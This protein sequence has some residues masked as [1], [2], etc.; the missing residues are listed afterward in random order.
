LAWSFGQQFTPFA[1]RRTSTDSCVIGNGIPRSGTYLV[2]NILQNLGGWEN[3]GVHI[4][5]RTW[6]TWQRDGRVTIHPC[7]ARFALQK[8]RNGQIVGAHLPWSRELEKAMGRVTV[9]RRIKQVFIH[10]DPRDTFVSYLSWVTTSERFL[11]TA[12]GKEFRKFMLEKFDNDDQRLSYIIGQ[13]QHSHSVYQSY[14]PWLQSPRCLAVKFEEL[15]SEISDL[16]D[17]IVGPVLGQLLRYVEI[18]VAGVDLTEFHSRVFGQSVT[19]IGRYK[20]VFKDQHYA[21]L[22]NPEFKNTLRT[23]G[24]EW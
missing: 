19:E 8:L 5:G 12:G 18:D 13:P 21:L 14:A 23:F 24:Y 7:V 17:G 9:Q 6:D 1:S 2:N 11:T 15:Y 3:I 10:R 20:K 4:N 16:K 22:D